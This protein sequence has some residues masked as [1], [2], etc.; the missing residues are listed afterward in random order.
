MI[1]CGLYMVLWGKSKEMRKN[2][3]IPSESTDKFDTVEIMVKPGVEDKSNN[4][5]VNAVN[6]V[7]DNEDSWKNGG[8]NNQ[9]CRPK[10]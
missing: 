6:G 5:L 7:G 4:I 8:E 3:R 2:E 10:K 9:C 1:I